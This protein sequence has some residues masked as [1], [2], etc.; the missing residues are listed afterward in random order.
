M[1]QLPLVDRPSPGAPR[2]PRAKARR[3]LGCGPVLI[4]RGAFRPS[5][6][7]SED[8]RKTREFGLAL[9]GGILGGVLGLLL[10]LVLASVALAGCSSSADSIDRAAAAGQKALAAVDVAATK[11]AEAHQS[12]AAAAVAFCRERYPDATKD[13]RAECL[14]AVGFSPDQVRAFEAALAEA[15]KIYNEL[16]DLLE[17]L[18]EVAPRL[19]AGIRAAE[20]I[21]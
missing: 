10:S 18:E 3:P 15:G 9:G 17:R 11:S 20:A 16:A 1:V 19:E 5:P 13:R 21:R 6:L 8:A 7:V 4:P 2:R 14:A 12:G